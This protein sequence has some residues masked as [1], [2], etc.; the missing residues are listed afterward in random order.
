MLYPHAV[1]N[2]SPDLLRA[3]RKAADALGVGIQIHAAQSTAEVA[4]TVAWYGRSPIELLHDTGVLGPDTI[5][6]HCIFINTHSMINRSGNDLGLIADSGTSVAHSPLK[7]LYAGFVMESFQRYID[8]G[9]NMTIGT[10]SFPSDFLLEM[11]TAAIAG[12]L[13]DRRGSVVRTEA[14]F[15]AATLGGARALGRSDIGRLA[16]GARADLLIVDTS[17]LDTGLVFDPIRALIHYCTARDIETVMIDGR[18]VIEHH[19]A[20]G[21]DEDD[22]LDR[23]RPI[24]ERLRRVL[25]DRNW[26]RPSVAD[27]FPPC[28]GLRPAPA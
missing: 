2:V 5:L 21:I 3:T 8:R 7:F 18:I 20:V 25:A 28:L 23:A 16:P 17:N 11:R 10:D 19:R 9:V 13:V 14:L 27:M 4:A 24:Y 1:D 26:N 6:G 15:D 22:L 12:K